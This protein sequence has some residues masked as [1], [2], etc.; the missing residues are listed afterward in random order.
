MEFDSYGQLW[1][2]SWLGCDIQTWPDLSWWRVNG[3]L[4]G[5]RWCRLII[6]DPRLSSTHFFLATEVCLMEMSHQSLEESL[7]ERCSSERKEDSFDSMLAMKVVFSYLFA[8]G[9]VSDFISKG[10]NWNTYGPFYYYYGPRY[11][12]GNVV[13]SLLVFSNPFAM[14][15]VVFV[16]ESGLGVI[17]FE[18]WTLRYLSNHCTT[19]QL[20][21]TIS[22]KVALLETINNAR[23]DRYGLTSEWVIIGKIDIL[24]VLSMNVQGVDW[25][26]LAILRLGTQRTLVSFKSVFFSLH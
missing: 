26:F 4:G 6:R 22:Q 1:V 20:K 12:P 9:L 5:S 13:S 8:T 17:S 15:E 3:Y 16:T 24:I 18:Q 25:K 10:G 23:H 14:S 19:L 2:G 11:H 7:Q 21:F